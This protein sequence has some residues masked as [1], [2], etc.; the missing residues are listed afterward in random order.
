MRSP[1]VPS[2]FA[3]QFDGTAGLRIGIDQASFGTLVQVA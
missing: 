1:D 3:I 2:V